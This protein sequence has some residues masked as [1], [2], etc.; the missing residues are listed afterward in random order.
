MGKY[1]H[2]NETKKNIPLRVAAVLLYLTLIS[3]YL[4]SGL[5]ARYAASGQV[6]DQA[7]VAAF[8]IEGG[9]DFYKSVQTNI[10]PGEPQTVS[11][12]IYNN[13]EVSVEYSVEVTNVTN[14]L[15]LTFTME[16]VD[17]SP[18]FTAESETGFTARQLPGSHTDQYK[19]TITWPE[20]ADDDA[21]ARALERM[22]MVDYITVKVTATQID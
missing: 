20:P 6:G 13:S 22:G 9:G 2:K 7:R 14:N 19:L 12:V 11:L 17:S 18:E 21:K 1:L 4:V 16:E 8:S 15:P 5:F 10:I 3:T